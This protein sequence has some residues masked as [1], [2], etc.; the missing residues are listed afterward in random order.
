V[1][2]AGVLDAE[3]VGRLWN[4]HQRGRDNVGWKLW[5]FFMLQSWL[6]TTNRK[7]QPQ[8]SEDSAASTVVTTA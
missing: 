7:T 2:E 1:R 4:A 6:R 3:A 8:R 5:T